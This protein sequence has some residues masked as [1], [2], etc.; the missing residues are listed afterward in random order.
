MHFG[1]DQDHF[2]G[3]CRR[4]LH[5]SRVTLVGR[6]WVEGGT[7]MLCV[8]ISWKVAICG[9]GS[10]LHGCA[11]LL[12]RV[13]VIEDPIKNACLGAQCQLGLHACAHT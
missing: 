8:L 5:S 12:V 7:E 10:A 11:M 9:P 3:V 6:H 1:A 13:Q 4:V 2:K